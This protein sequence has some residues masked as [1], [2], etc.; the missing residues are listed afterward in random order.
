VTEAVMAS[1]NSTI[2]LNVGGVLYTTTTFTLQKYPDS[3]LGALISGKFQTTLDTN[4]H[5]F[6]DRDGRAFRH[7]LNFLRTSALC[8]PS[9]FTEL[10]LLHAEADFYQ[11]EP[12]VNLLNQHRELQAS[13]GTTYF[14]EIIEVRTGSTATMPTNNSRVRTILSG[15]KD[16]I[17]SLPPSVIG[18]D[19]SEKLRYKR[20]VTEHAELE[21]Y[22]SNI[23]LR[24]GEAL[25]SKGWQQVA[26]NLSSSSGFDTKSMHSIL[27]IEHSYRDRWSILLKEGE[28]FVIHPDHF[29]ANGE[30]NEVADRSD[31]AGDG[32]WMQ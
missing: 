28:K 29:K 9:D 20:E 4:G 32:E 8:I 15:R 13:R 27:V 18:S 22:G 30:Q 12:L 23:R 7:I 11:I 24:V 2:T 5:I 6:I 17:L 14:L 25:E 3:M 21:L 16:A 1:S 19:I 26:S 31:D 10:D